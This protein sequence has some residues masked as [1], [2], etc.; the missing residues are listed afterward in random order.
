VSDQAPRRRIRRVPPQQIHPR[1]KRRVYDKLKAYTAQTGATDN[2]VLNAALE[3]Y[4][5]KSWDTALIIRRLDR[6][7]RG[8]ARA[9][10]Q[11]DTLAE[12]LS[13]FIQIWFAHTPPI[14]EEQ[15]NTAKH[16]A[17]KRYADMIEF[18]RRRLGASKH[19]LVDLLGADEA[20]E[21]APEPSG[22]GRGNADGLDA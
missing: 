14:P 2:A 4:L 16:S 9:Q 18:I 21:L 10:R 8:L 15:K 20:D 19:V 13:A 22:S 12:V 7:S 6:L 3:Q 1:L 17:N 5:D 11:T